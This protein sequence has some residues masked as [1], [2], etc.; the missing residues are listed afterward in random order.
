MMTLSGKSAALGL[1]LLIGALGVRIACAQQAV[2]EAEPEA[3]QADDGDEPKTPDAAAE[4][5]VEF[6]A[7]WFTTDPVT[8]ER[9]PGAVELEGQPMPRFKIDGWVTEGFDFNE[10]RGKILVVDFWSLACGPCMKQFHK[11]VELARR[12]ADRDVVVISLHDYSK[13]RTRIP[14]MVRQFD[15]DHPI[16]VDQFDIT[17]R[18]WDIA[19]RP[20]YN[21]VDRYGIVRA[22]GVR[23]A[24]LED[25]IERLLAE[26]YDPDF[27]PP[28]MLDQSSRESAPDDRD[29]AEIPEQWLEGSQRDRRQ[30]TNLVDVRRPPA[31]ESTQW[32]NSESMTLAALR[33][34]V[35][36]LDFWA[37]WCI[38]CRNA[39]PKTNALYEKYKQHGLEIIGICHPTAVNRMNDTVTQWDIRFPVCADADGTIH[40]AYQVSGWPDYY[41][42]DRYGE[43]RAI[44]CSND[45]VEDVVKLLLE[46]PGPPIRGEDAPRAQPTIK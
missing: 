5:N 40:T 13:A 24:H 16:G 32:V 39:V 23:R 26:P 36:L 7:S 29:R 14:S 42:I 45:H 17:A 9:Y 31:I 12:Y 18:A 44:D 15:A 35:V 46:E 11:N 20:S 3:V 38:P 30:F 22:A 41:I 10:H 21:V 19:T 2:T 27:I 43:L 28:Q 33:G 25:V 37:T 4:P 34:K 1:V 8:N 6:P